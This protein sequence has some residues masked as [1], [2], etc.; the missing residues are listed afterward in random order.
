MLLRFF[1]WSIDLFNVDWLLSLS[2][3]IVFILIVFLL[4]CLFN[5]LSRLSYFRCGCAAFSTVFISL[6]PLVLAYIWLY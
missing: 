5:E 6:F 4:F 2:V 3:G 1:M